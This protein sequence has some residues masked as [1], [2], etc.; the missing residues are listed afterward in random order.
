MALPSLTVDKHHTR[1][2]VRNRL[3]EVHQ[4]LSS[5]QAGRSSGKSTFLFDTLATKILLCQS[6]GIPTAYGI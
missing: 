4:T 3:V 1:S 2:S 5:D 6:D